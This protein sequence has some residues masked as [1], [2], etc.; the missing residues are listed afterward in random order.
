M[1]LL[2]F[3]MM[4]IWRFFC[5]R[6]YISVPWRAMSARKSCHVDCGFVTIIYIISLNLFTKYQVIYAKIRNTL[7]YLIIYM[8]FVLPCFFVV[9]VDIVAVIVVVIALLFLL[10]S[11]N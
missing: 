11:S 9:V 8:N 10:A 4:P 7:N 6:L 2:W 1:L 5:R 3:K